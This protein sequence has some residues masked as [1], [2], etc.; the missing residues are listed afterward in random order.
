[1]AGSLQDSFLDECK[2]QRTPVTV[3]LASGVELRGVVKGFD[4]FTLLLAGE[5]T[6]FLVYKHAVATIAPD[7]P[8]ADTIA[9]A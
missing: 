6:T 1:M 4:P 5:R 2:Q 3:C 8:A 7:A 9:G